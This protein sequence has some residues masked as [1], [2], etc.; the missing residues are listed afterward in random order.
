MEKQS[1]MPLRKVNNATIKYVNGNNADEI[2]KN[3]LKRA[4]IQMVKEIKED[5]YKHLN[6]YEV[7]TSK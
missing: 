7:N 1:T 6:E 2:S 3:E 5:M 4:M